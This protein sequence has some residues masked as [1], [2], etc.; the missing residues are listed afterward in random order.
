[1][2]D[3]RERLRH[4]WNLVEYR[5]AYCR[6]LVA[7]NALFLVELRG[8]VAAQRQNEMSDALPFLLRVLDD[9]K[10]IVERIDLAASDECRKVQVHGDG[11]GFGVLID[12]IQNF[13]GNPAVL[14]LQ[15]A[16]RRID[17][18]G[19]AGTRR[20]LQGLQESARCRIEGQHIQA[21]T[22]KSVASQDA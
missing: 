7:I 11:V 17:R 2:A 19:D 22:R 9:G 13:T 1:M 18:I 15:S 12:D 8:A 6:S 4:L 3:D 14:L 10:K 5:N 21:D 20:Q 16:H